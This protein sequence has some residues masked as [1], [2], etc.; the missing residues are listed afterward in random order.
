MTWNFAWILQVVSFPKDNRINIIKQISPNYGTGIKMKY[1][2][3]NLLLVEFKGRWLLNLQ[4]H[5]RPETTGWRRFNSRLGPLL[6]LVG[7]VAG[8]QTARKKWWCEVLGARRARKEGM[9]SKFLNYVLLS[10]RRKMI[11]LCQERRQHVI[12]IPDTCDVS[13]ECFIAFFSTLGVHRAI[14]FFSRFS[15]ASNTTD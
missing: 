15:F 5:E 3:R 2:P 4:I 9:P 11:G 14:F 7:C 10:Q 1:S 6:Y 13:Q 12:H 8:K